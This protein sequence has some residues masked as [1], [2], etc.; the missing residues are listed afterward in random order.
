MDFL[1]LFAIYVVVVLTCIVLVCKYSGRQ[2]TPFSIISNSIV[3]VRK[4]EAFYLCFQKQTLGGAVVALQSHNGVFSSQVVAPFT[5]K[6]LQR[7][8]QWTMHRLF[9][10]RFVVKVPPG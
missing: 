2:Q 8:S 4:K 1:T 9:H 7:F 10:Q 6:W 3:K 5:P